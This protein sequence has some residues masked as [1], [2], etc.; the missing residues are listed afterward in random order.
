MPVRHRIERAGVDSD[1]LFQAASDARQ[2]SCNLTDLG[3]GTFRQRVSKP[4]RFYSL[5]NPEAMS[6]SKHYRRQ[7]S[8]SLSQLSMVNRISSKWPAK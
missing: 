7:D 8:S 2:A 5:R 1:Y 6:V 4:L 3:P